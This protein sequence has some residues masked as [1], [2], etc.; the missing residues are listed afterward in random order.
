[1]KKTIII[2]ATILLAGVCGQA[3]TTTKQKPTVQPRVAVAPT[4]VS[5]SF[6]KMALHTLIAMRN[7][8]G[9]TVAAGHIETLLEDMEVAQSTPT[10]EFLTHQ[11]GSLNTLH[12]LRLRDFVKSRSSS[13]SSDQAAKDSG[14]SIDYA[15]FDAYEA[16]LKANGTKTDL[17]KSPS[18]CVEKTS[19]EAF[20]EKSAPAR[21]KNMA[22]LMTAGANHDAIDSCLKEYLSE[23][24]SINCSGKD[25]RGHF[26]CQP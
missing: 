16:M 22:C 15:C 19:T 9:S 26:T 14:V 20:L 3:Q 1:M 17:S 12:S 2:T 7:S 10:E 21:A 25:A 6:A 4:A 8:D 18:V 5:D 24:K 13:E 11:F 23:L